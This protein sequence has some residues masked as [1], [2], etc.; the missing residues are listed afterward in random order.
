MSKPITAT[1]PNLKPLIPGLGD[2]PELGPLV[3][4]EGDYWS[5]GVGNIEFAA[6]GD[7]II[8]LEDQFESG[9]GCPVCNPTGSGK[10][11][12]ERTTIK[13]ESCNGSGKSRVVH[14]ALCKDCGGLGKLVCRACDGLGVRKGGIL[15]PDDATRRPTTGV[16]VSA[17][18][19]RW[20]TD[21]KLVPNAFVVGDRVM[22]SNFAG[23]VVDLTR[24]TGDPVCLRI[25]HDTEAFCKIRGHIK[26]SDLK[27]KS[28]IALAS[29]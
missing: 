15:T 14:G 1:S 2:Q 29:S 28:D 17:G 7:R 12:T 21:G 11:T 6:I 27:G 9:M 23:Y 26:L 25:L 13:C 19:G 4:L 10:A 5:T 20:T 22:Y 18:P 16:V 3:A 8:V 24:A